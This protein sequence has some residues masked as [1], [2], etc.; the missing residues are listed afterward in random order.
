[1]AFIIDAFTFFNGAVMA[2]LQV[3]T[4]IILPFSRTADGLAAGDHPGRDG[5]R[6]NYGQL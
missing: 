5:L 2:R 3:S 4:A 6:E 1:M